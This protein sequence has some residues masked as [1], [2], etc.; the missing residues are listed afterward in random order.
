MLRKI[1]PFADIPV[2]HAPQ[3]GLQPFQNF[4]N[5]PGLK[6]RVE[7]IRNSG[8]HKGHLPPA[9]PLVKK[10]RQH[11]RDFS[12]LPENHHTERA[13]PEVGPPGQ[14]PFGPLKRSG[15]RD[16]SRKFPPFGLKLRQTNVVF[17]DFKRYHIASIRAGWP[18]L[19]EEM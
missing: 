2:G 7:I 5:V 10:A 14:Q 12:G 6:Q 16:S 9:V 4:L 17:D 11:T 18:C 3:F 15:L 13:A 19:K 8:A 1:L